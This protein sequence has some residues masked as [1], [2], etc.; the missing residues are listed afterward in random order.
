MS[1]VAIDP[2]EGEGEGAGAGEGEG[3]RE[4]GAL[5][6]PLTSAYVIAA[7]MAMAMAM[8][9]ASGPFSYRSALGCIHIWSL[10][11]PFFFRPI[12]KKTRPSWWKGNPYDMPLRQGLLICC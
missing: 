5:G 10:S 8:A 4:G 9:L 6:A 11:L 2:R 3:A 7:A 12:S 1:K